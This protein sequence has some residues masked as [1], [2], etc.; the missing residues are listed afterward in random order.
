MIKPHQIENLENSSC[1]GFLNSQF[2]RFEIYESKQGETDY[3]LPKK[4]QA[5]RELWIAK[6]FPDNQCVMKF[7]DEQLE[8]LFAFNH[9][10]KKHKA[11][12][13][14]D[15]KSHGEGGWAV[16]IKNKAMTKQYK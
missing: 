13:L 12:L 2:D 11:L 3:S 1:S 10:N 5:K 6:N 7:Y 4:E 9:Y 8:A 15:L 16:C 14:W